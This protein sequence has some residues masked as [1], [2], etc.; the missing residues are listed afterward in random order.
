MCA[1][2]LTSLP[3]T[4]LLIGQRRLRGRG[5]AADGVVR[6]SQALTRLVEVAGLRRIQTGVAGFPSFRAGAHL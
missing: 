6:R 4:R 3:A 2:L 5:L 1:H